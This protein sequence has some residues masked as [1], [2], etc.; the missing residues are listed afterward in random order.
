[1]VLSGMTDISEAIELLAQLGVDAKE[2]QVY[3][4]LIKTPNQSITELSKNNSI[5]RTTLYRVCESLI[6]KQ[7][8]RKL[9]TA[10]SEVFIALTP[11]ELGHLRLA[12]QM[13]L[14]LIQESITR[15]QSALSK[16]ISDSQNTLVFIKTTDDFYR[17]LYQITNQEEEIR[18]IVSHTYNLSKALDTKAVSK[19]AP[20]VDRIKIIYAGTDQFAHSKINI[21]NPLTKFAGIQLFTS[22][23]YVSVSGDLKQLSGISIQDNNMAHNQLQ[24]FSNFWNQSV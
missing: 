16:E 8:V 17:E 4:S 20:K 2:S 14:E 15:L 12:K 19:I 7:F 22:R 24:L 1:M 9:T 11:D 3:I 23:K 6:A 5:P 18:L 10:D 21:R 13:E